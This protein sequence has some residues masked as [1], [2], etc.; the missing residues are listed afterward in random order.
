MTKTSS[1]LKAPVLITE[2]PYKLKNFKFRGNRLILG[3]E[4]DKL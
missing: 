3:E 2:P 4:K 1:Q